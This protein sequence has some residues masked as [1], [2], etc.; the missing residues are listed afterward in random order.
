VA[1][2]AG[3]RNDAAELRK[4]LDVSLPKADG[5]LHDWQ[6]VVL[7]GGVVNGISLA[8]KWPA[9]RMKELLEGSKG[10]GARWKRALEEASRMADNTKVPA[11]T[12]YDALRMIAMEGFEKR[13]EQLKKYLAKGTHDELTMGAISGLSDVDSEKVAPLLLAGLGHFSAGNRKLAVEA[14]LRTEGRALALLGA[15]EAGKVRKAELSEEQ[16]RALRKHTSEKV[17]R[18]AVKALGQ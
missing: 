17:R 16:Q 14:L 7:G 11:G 9:E 1:I 6:A 15:V 13:G 10:R 2:A 4:V 3:R 18:R 12:R 5:P 8:G